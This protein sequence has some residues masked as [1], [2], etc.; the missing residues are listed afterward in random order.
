MNRYLKRILRPVWGALRPL[1]ERAVNFSV[2]ALERFARA[3]VARRSTRTW[4]NALYRLLTLGGKRRFYEL[5]GAAFRN[6]ETPIEDGEWTVQF[7]RKQVAFPLTSKRIWLDWESAL[8]ALGHESFIKDTYL[9]FLTGPYPPECF[10]DIGA[11]Y[12]NH[13]LLFLVHGV[14]VLTFEPNSSCHAYFREICE[15]NHV[16]PQLESKALGAAR[17]ETSLSYPPR[18]TWLGSI[19]QNTVEH[20]R[21]TTD[22]I[23]ECVQVGVLDDYANRLAGRRALIKIDAEG[24][25]AS[26]LQGAVSTLR[27]L[28]APVLFESWP[29]NAARRLEL[30]GYFREVDYCIAELPVL[31]ARRANVLSDAAFVSSLGSDFIGFGAERAEDSSVE[32]VSADSL[33]APRGSDA[34]GHSPKATRQAPRLSGSEESD[35]A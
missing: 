22:L 21:T 16:R 9:A 26:I 23:T 24:H 11:N 1:R 30:L 18:Q 27:K 13:S 4:L 5:F 19:D 12:G 17:G 28:R 7:G 15:L 35:G 34:A 25:E 6:A 10:V 31:R 8:A 20:L 3:I 32:G 33:L 29:G 14:E 2:D